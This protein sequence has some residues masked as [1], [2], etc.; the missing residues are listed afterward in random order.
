M[1]FT[2]STTNFSTTEGAAK[3]TTD[4]FQIGNPN[5]V[6]DGTNNQYLLNVEIQLKPGVEHLQVLFT[7]TK[8]LLSY[9]QWVDSSAKFMSKAVQPDGPPIP[10]YKQ[11]QTNTGHP[12]ISRHKTG[13]KP[14]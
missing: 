7:E 3:P 11:L 5:K 1:N 13:S 2:D 4:N 8:S 9:I 10:H 14:Q 12:A 6:F